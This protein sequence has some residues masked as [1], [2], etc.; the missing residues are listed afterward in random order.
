MEA[1][2]SR[3]AARGLAA[4]AGFGADPAMLMHVGMP[5]ALLGADTAGQ[6]ARGKLGDDHGFIAA[7]AAGS[8]VGR[9][10]ADVSAIEIDTD[11]LTKLGDHILTEARVGARRADLG[12]FETLLDAP[13]EGVVR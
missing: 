3:H 9:C 5:L 4:A 1:E 8:D 12:A 7:G 13:D 2:A 11:A 6:F 10:G